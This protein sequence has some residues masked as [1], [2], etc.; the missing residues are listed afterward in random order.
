[1][2]REA[3]C[4]GAQARQDRA[5]C[6]CCQ[7]AGAAGPWQSARDPPPPPREAAVRRRWSLPTKG[8]RVKAAHR[9]VSWWEPQ[10]Q[11][12]GFRFRE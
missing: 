12:V 1:M 6:G 11:P 10:R 4:A 7:R 9:C 3:T 8:R 2:T 5:D